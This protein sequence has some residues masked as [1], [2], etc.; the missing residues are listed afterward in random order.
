MANINLYCLH[1]GDCDP[2]KCTAIKLKKLNKLKF[3]DKITGKL[4]Q[5]IF[6]NPFSSKE[7][8]LK[9]RR[10][11]LKYGLVVI[12][13]SWNK[14]LNRNIPETQNPRRLPS[15]VAA[16]P[17]NYGKWEKLSSAEAI[18]AALYLTGFSK[19]AKKLANLFRWGQEF[20]RINNFK[21]KI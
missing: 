20:L 16:N 18:I 17:I 4:K 21:K 1:Y 13:C 14:I 10:I 6:L 15:L 9:D 8:S 11:V 12:D 3:L 5:A 7:I 2:D 19:N